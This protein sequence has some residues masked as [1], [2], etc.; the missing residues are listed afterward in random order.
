LK[1]AP[2]A[3]AAVERA[4][5]ENIGRS[6]ANGR[7]ELSNQ[8]HGNSAGEHASVS[9]FLFLSVDN[10]WRWLQVVQAM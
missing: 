8:C 2:K 3:E 9:D 6:P 1:G 5:N 10:F 4:V 7:A